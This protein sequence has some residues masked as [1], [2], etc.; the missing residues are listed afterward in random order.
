MS[1][2]SAS[3]I[4]LVIL[5]PVAIFIFVRLQKFEDGGSI[6]EILSQNGFVELKPPSTL[7]PPGT[8]VRVLSTNPLH[9]GVVCPPETALGL[10][11]TNLLLYSSSADTETISKLS[12]S[13]DLGAKALAKVKGESKF[14]EVKIISLYLKNIRVIELPDDVVMQG[15]QKRA[16][17]CR[18]AIRFR[19]EEMKPVSMIKSVLIADVY[20][21]VEFNRELGSGTEANLKKQLAMELDL[22]MDVGEDGSSSLVGRNL[23]WGIREDPQLAKAG[24]GLP[25]TGG[26]NDGTAVLTS[27]GAVTKISLPERRKFAQGKTVVSYDV[28]PLRQSSAM[29]C[30]ATVYTMMK[31]WKVKSALSVNSV[32]A[33]IGGPWD[34]YYLKDTGLPGG[35][36]KAFVEVV[37][38]KSKPPANY[39]IA[40]YIQMLHGNGPLWIITGDGISAHARLLVGIY[41]NFDAEGIRAY[42]ESTFE[43]IDPLSG[44]YRYESGL[45][46]AHKF[47]TEARWLVDGKFDDVE[48]RSQILHWP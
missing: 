5:V 38:M 22:R 40:A 33:N 9:L 34:D 12:S 20:Y 31:S 48:L 28:T 43:F 23:I 44:T 11:G 42:E 25:A 26:A 27:K 21:R 19:I 41:G 46:F 4:A 29:S 45:D 15:L 47:E 14:S 6:G 3:L 7:V 32:V 39:T 36:E 1:Q 2:R 16:P 30:W 37:G 17:H 24:L 13:F 10:D 18:E 35:K 8:W